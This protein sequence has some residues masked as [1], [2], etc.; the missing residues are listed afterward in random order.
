MVQKSLLSL[1]L[2]AFS[3]SMI[4]K[5]N[6]PK[7][8]KMVWHDEFKGKAL[9]KDWTVVE[10]PAGW[11]NHE[12]Q[13]YVTMD[14]EG[15]SPLKVSDGTLKITAY[16]A[17]DGKIYSGRMNACQQTGWQYGYME[18]RIKLPKGKGTWPAFWMMPV[19]GGRWPA[20]GEIDIMEEIGGDAN[21]IHSTIHTRKYNNTGTPIE[22]GHR[23]IEGAEGEFHIYGMEWTPEHMV[24]Y[25]DGEQL[26]DYKNEG[27]ED[28]WP[29]D[30]PFYIILNLAFGGDWGG[31]KG[32]DHTV[33]PITMEVDYVRVYQKK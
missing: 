18:S 8:Y 24:F 14:P 5:G 33:L 29:Y 2:L 31:C 11:V 21:M 7:G 20:C 30:K 26:L 6:I 12:L 13:T 27:T 17:K 3:V 4:A 23:R 1:V 19:G 25:V 16:K 28:A 22:N 32:V 10:K 15:V 9:N